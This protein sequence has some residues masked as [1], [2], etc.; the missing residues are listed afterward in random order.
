MLTDEK[1]FETRKL[2]CK[3]ESQATAICAGLRNSG[4]VHD[5]VQTPKNAGYVLEYSFDA[6]NKDKITAKLNEILDSQIKQ[7]SGLE[8]SR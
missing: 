4:L 5:V 3:Y 1:M 7:I 2:F 6:A 8:Q